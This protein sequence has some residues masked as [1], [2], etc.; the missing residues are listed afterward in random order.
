MK[1]TKVLVIILIITMAV[2]V[3]GGEWHTPPSPTHFVNS[4]ST[5]LTTSNIFTEK[6]SLTFDADDAD[7]LIQYTAEET[8]SDSGTTVVNRVQIDDAQTIHESDWHPDTSN[9]IGYGTMSGFTI[10]NFTGG[11]HTIDLDFASGQDGK[12]VSVRRARIMATKVR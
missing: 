2:I 3:N 9:S 11:S 8:S 12:E 10:I 4:S 6:V 5:T 7:Y 1:V